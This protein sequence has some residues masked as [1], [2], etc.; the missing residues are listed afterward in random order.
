MEELGCFR[1]TQAALY[2]FGPCKLPDHFHTRIITRG[3]KAY[4]S[5]SLMDLLVKHTIVI[6]EEVGIVLRALLSVDGARARRQLKLVAKVRFWR[7]LRPRQ[8]G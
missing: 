3:T 7:R 2:G 1:L 6:R 8:V 4:L 5:D